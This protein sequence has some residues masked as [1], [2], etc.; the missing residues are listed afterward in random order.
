MN[1]SNFPAKQ[2]NRRL[3]VINRLET[4]LKIGNKRTMEGFVPLA[5]SDIKRIKREIE[6][7]KTRIPLSPRGLR[8]KKHSGSR[9][10]RS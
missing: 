7:L 9:R 6:T 4:Q 3:D 1:T 5:D 10:Y 2:A 8:S